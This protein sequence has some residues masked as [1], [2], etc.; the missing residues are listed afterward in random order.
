MAEHG[1]GVAVRRKEDIRFTTG[2]GRYTDD[3]T[4]PN[5]AFAYVLRSPVAHARLNQVGISQA[6]RSDGVLAVITGRDLQAQGIGGLPCGWS[7]TSKDGS[8]MP[9]PP[10]PAM[11]IDRIRY[12]GE[13]VAVVVAESKAQAQDAAELIELDYEDLDAVASI[14]SAL[15]DDAPQI[16]DEVSGNQLFDWEI[17]DE[18]ATKAAFDRAASVVSLDLVNNRLVC[19]AMEPRS[20]LA[21]YDEAS[22]SFTLH[23]ASQAPHL[24][25]MGLAAM[26][27]GIPENKLRVISPDVG[28][29]FGSKAF[30]YAE[31]IL[32]TVAARQIRRPVKWTAERSESFLSDAQGRDHVTHARLALD[33]E[34]HFLGLH[35]S[36]LANLGAHISPSGPAVPTFYYAPLLA[37]CYKTPAIYCEVK[38]VFTN[39]VPVDAYRGAGRPEATYVVERLVDKAARDLNIDPVALRKRNFISPDAFPYQTPLSLCYDSGDYDATLDK[40]LE[41]ADYD[42]F[43]ARRESAADSG[44]LRGFGISCYIEACGVA[45]SQVILN[46]GGRS[47]L[48]ESAKVRVNPTG[49]ITVMTGSHSHGQSHETTFAQ[50]VNERLGVPIDQV[51][52]VQGDTAKVQF[53]TGTYGSRSLVVGGAAMLKAMDNIIEKGRRIAGHILEAS[54]EDIE[55]AE[56][57]FTVAGTDRALSFAEVALAA[58]VPHN[59]PHDELEPGLEEQAFYDPKDFTFPAGAH[60]CEVE[61]DPDTGI[62]EIVGFSVADDFGRVIN[63]MVVEGQVHGGVAQGVGQA[64]L[65]NC[66]YDDDGAQLLSASFMDYTMP[67][68]DNLPPIKVATEV[69]LCQTNPLGSKG[70]GEAGA[71][72]A[73]PAVINA[74]LD[75]LKVVGVTE[76]DMPATPL[77]VWQAIQAAR[78]A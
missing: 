76:F 17:G 10:R 65:E 42:G 7:A 43:E 39:T 13:P 72:A 22:D 63:P 26:I 14:T 32:V 46:S 61:I 58:Y 31:E 20:C 18:A 3:L 54:H 29:G 53:G 24:I 68:A 73:P 62:V 40:A 1:I 71:I 49:S 6:Q 19:N 51:D 16:H 15:A 67:R 69:T 21:Q 38:G 27:L 11:A 41:L 50:L 45:P 30:P 60:L 23:L 70:C 44:K 56:G 52:V 77:R 47:G 37:G 8:V 33:S 28:G 55:F 9:E 78:R 64:M 34:G 35:V 4:V 59:Y 25:R 48:Y 2:R 5:Q 74:V 12:V 57:N 36:T 75:A 66:V